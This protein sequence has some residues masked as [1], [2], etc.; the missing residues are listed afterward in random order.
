MGV[1]RQ[2]ATIYPAMLL[3]TLGVFVPS[4]MLRAA[5][6][7]AASCSYADVSS[8]ISAAAKGDTVNVPAGSCTWSSTLLI[9]KGISLIGGNGGV[10]K[11]TAG[12]G[13]GNFIIQ[14][15]PADY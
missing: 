1:R 7:A 12:L 8:A 13:A 2:S 5:T 15:N 10:T 14:I 6:I 4:A 9:N 3:F 11:I